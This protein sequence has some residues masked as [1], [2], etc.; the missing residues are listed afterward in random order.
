MA[1]L[2]ILTV[3][4]HQL[5][6]DGLTTFLKEEPSFD[7]IGF[8]NNGQ[9]AV[10]YVKTVRVDLILMDIDMPVLNGLDATQR[11]KQ[12]N[13][14][15]KII[16]LTMHDEK[17]L[18]KRFMEIGADGYALK[19]TDKNLLIEI[20]KKVASGK[21]HFPDELLKEKEN[22]VK[23]II[24][25]PSDAILKS[26]LT[27]REIEIL[28]LISQGFSNKEIGD[29]LFISHRTVDTHRTNLMKKLDVSNIAGLIKKSYELKI[30]E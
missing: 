9:Q 27:D 20:I 6:I 17:S 28:S 1:L 29:K 15:I 8:C 13:P 3:D 26:Q 23:K 16:I 18:V 22:S 7:H 10:D 2:K 12:L 4:D 24:D 19:N 5:I 30:I 14:D 25:Q 11:I 21:K